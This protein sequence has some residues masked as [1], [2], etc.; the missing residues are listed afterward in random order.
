M[1]QYYVLFIY[2]YIFTYSFAY[3][4][5]SPLSKAKNTGSYYKSTVN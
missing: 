4:Y 3:L 2:F 1:R 5:S